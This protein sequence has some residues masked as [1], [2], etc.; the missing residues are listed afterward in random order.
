MSYL[1]KH[2]PTVIVGYWCYT[3]QNV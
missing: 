1:A 2:R 3:F